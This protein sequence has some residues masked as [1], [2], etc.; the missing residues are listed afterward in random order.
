MDTDKPKLYLN[1]ILKWDEPVDMVKR[2][3]DSIKDY[4]DAMYIAVTYQDK[5][6]DENNELVKF[7][8]SYNANVLFFKWTDSFADARQ[9]VLDNT[10]HGEE[11]YIIWIDADDVLRGSENLPKLLDEAVRLKHAAVFFDYWYMVDLDDK[12]EVREIIIKHKRERIIR[13]DGTFKWAG[14]LHEVLVD[15][16][17]ENVIKVPREECVV[18]HLSNQQR[19]DR[20]LKRNVNILNKQAA[21]EQHRDPR[22]LIYLAKAYFD[23]AKMSGDIKDRKIME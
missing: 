20:N 6:P 4:V 5:K 11:T 14:R 23:Q 19:I 1:M 3:I 10:P 15:Q 17:T 7:L 8:K 18:L 22:T 12:G 21:E 16:R 13:N 9:F 2:A